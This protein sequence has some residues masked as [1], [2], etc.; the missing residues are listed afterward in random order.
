MENK[1]ITLK[2]GNILTFQHTGFQKAQEMLKAA[3][4]EAKK[5]GI[6]IFKLSGEETIESE[7]LSDVFLSIAVSDSIESLFWQCASVCLWQGE[8][9]LPK[10]FDERE[11]ATGD[12]LEIKFHIINETVS[13]FFSNLILK[14]SAAQEPSLK[15]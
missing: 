9:I 15:K 2:S 1:E 6:D 7:T 8:R 12:F 13:V 10:L 5:C 3:A 4:R 11:E 14:S